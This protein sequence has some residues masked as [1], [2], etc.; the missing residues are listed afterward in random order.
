MG[1]QKTNLSNEKIE[2]ILRK[3]YNIVPNKIIEVNRGTANIFKIDT[4][5]K[6]Y[7]L[8]EFN[9]K[10]TV[11]SVKKEIDIINFLKKR[12]ICVPQYIKTINKAIKVKLLLYTI[13]I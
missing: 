12:N 13:L 6:S 4:D 9:Q 7:I 3:E 11:E 1:I 2:K 8:K 5:I 10:R